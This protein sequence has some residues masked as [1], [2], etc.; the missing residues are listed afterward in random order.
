MKTQNP[1]QLRI[2]AKVAVPTVLLV[3][4]SIG[5]LE[6]KALYDLDHPKPE[7]VDCLQCHSSKKALASIVDKSGDPQYLVHAGV[8]TQAQLD[9][10][11]AKVGMD[12][13]SNTPSVPYK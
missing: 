13:K 4:T 10:L 2:P 7:K 9:S 5:L 8:L 12:K 11:N 3:A 1:K 6:W